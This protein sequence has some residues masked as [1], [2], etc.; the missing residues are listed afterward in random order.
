M[1]FT[2]KKFTIKFYI[3]LNY[4]FNI[5]S[6]PLSAIKKKKVSESGKK[7]YKSRERLIL[8]I[9]QSLGFIKEV[10]VLD[11]RSLFFKI[12]K[13]N[14][15]TTEYQSV[16]LNVI[17]KIPR[18]VFEVLAVL[19]CLLVVNFFYQDSREQLLPILT[20]Y[21]ISLV[22]LIPSYS[23]IT[24]SILNIKF[25]RISFDMIC[26]ELEI[27]EPKL[28]EE[29]TYVSNKNLI[30]KK[31]KIISVDNLSFSYEEKKKCP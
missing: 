16:F 26:N 1:Y 17:N 29:K 13:D 11:K 23:Q 21:G 7:F 28:I 9:Q 12:F 14:L 3:Y 2:F 30:Y 27:I 19:I 8:N 6:C 4:F 22:R 25:F 18:L 5:F 20:L 10:I 15:Y 24:S 31:N